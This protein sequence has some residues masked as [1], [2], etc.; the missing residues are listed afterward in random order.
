MF[1]FTIGIRVVCLVLV[2]CFL[3]CC[4][5]KDARLGF[6][7]VFRFLLS[8]FMNSLVVSPACLGIDFSVP[9]FIFG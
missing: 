1:C 6:L 3:S 4:K 5:G 2:R 7:R 9:L 8:N